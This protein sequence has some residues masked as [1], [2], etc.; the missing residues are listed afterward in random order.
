MKKILSLL[1]VL[2]FVF[3][4]VSCGTPTKLDVDCNVYAIKGPTGVGMVPL[5]ELEDDDNANLDYDFELVGSNEEIIAKI[6]NK[7]A[8]IAA[9][10]T[11]LA[12]TLYN[13]T[14][15]GIS[16]LAINTLG[17]LS[18]VAKGEEISTIS[19]LKGKTIY[20]TGQGANPEYI[21][22]YVLEKNNLKAGEDVKIEFVAQPT[23]LVAKVVGNEK[24]IVVAPQPVAT[25]ITVKDEAAKIVMDIND[26]WDKISDTDLVMGCIIARKEYI[27]Q[28]PDAI[29]I[30]LK[31][32]EASI[33]SV[34]EDID[35][36]AALC[37]EYEIVTPAAV[38]KKA[39]PHCNIVY[40]DG[41][42]MKENLSAYLNFLYE[43]SNASVGGKL[44]ADDF[45]YAEK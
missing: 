41:K 14:N 20:S 13:K 12:S 21:I 1:L 34:N 17:V 25:A 33:K 2:V 39:I 38:A 11:N 26:E 30:F 18:V 22:N 36:A 4:L 45:Y 35:N 5:M 6:A 29:K 8:D 7:E 31:D 16:V 23:E 40:Q 24:A 19:D 28:N 44:P 43:K 9:V 3:T 42:E 37:E 10:A 27:E 15:G 32:Y